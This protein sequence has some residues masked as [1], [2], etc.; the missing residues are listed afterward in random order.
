MISIQEVFFSF[1]FVFWCIN[2]IRCLQATCYPVFMEKLAACATAVESRVEIDG[3]IVTSR[4]PGTTMEFSV[5]L[6]E[7]LLGKEK[8]VEVSGPLVCLIPD[9]SINLNLVSK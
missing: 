9:S 1:E 8:A 7:Q 2:H 3:K 6:V 4:G 5:T